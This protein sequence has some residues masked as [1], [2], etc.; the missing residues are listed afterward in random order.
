MCKNTYPS[1]Y[2]SR[3]LGVFG[4]IREE[5]GVHFLSSEKRL[6]KVR[7]HEALGSFREVFSPAS[8]NEVTLQLRFGTDWNRNHELTSDSQ[9]RVFE[10]GEAYLGRLS[11]E[12]RSDKQVS[13]LYRTRSYWRSFRTLPICTFR[14]T[15]SM[16]WRSW[17]CTCKYSVVVRYD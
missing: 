12:N 1:T 4:I 7:S 13:R 9:F 5:R 15:D 16:V 10:V 6:N 17:W 8:A 14:T 3:A 11:C 2:V